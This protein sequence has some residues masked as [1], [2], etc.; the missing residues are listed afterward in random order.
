MFLTLEELILIV[1]I[2]F[3]DSN[4]DHF[5]LF[6][7]NLNVITI[8]GIGNISTFLVVVPFHLLS[9]FFSE[10][11]VEGENE[12]DVVDDALDEGDEEIDDFKDDGN[13]ALRGPLLEVV[14]LD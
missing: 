1:V 5:L 12:N 13:E 10:H 3:R 2:L 14:G 7:Y 8:L 4:F 11:S 9:L 6:F